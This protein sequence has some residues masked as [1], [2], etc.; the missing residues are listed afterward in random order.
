MEYVVFMP[1]SIDPNY[2][3]TVILFFICG[4]AIGGFC[5]GYDLGKS[6]M[7]KRIITK[8]RS[9]GKVDESILTFLED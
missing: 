4:G 1:L 5:M 9:S 2:L 8:L 3:F 6:R 7:R